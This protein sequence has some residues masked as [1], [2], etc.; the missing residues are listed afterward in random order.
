MLAFNVFLS[1]HGL[2][3]FGAFVQLVTL[4]LGVCPWDFHPWDFCPMEL[5]SFRAFVLHPPRQDKYT[6]GGTMYDVNIN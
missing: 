2:L 4:A 3:Q 1:Y 6:V 5:L